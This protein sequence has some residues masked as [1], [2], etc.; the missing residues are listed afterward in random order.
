MSSR[1]FRGR[2]GLAVL[3]GTLFALFAFV[4]SVG[5]PAWL[6]V[7]TGNPA[8]RTVNALT[9]NK[10]VRDEAARFF[11]EKLTEDD[12]TKDLTR[13]DELQASIS[14]KL[15]ELVKDDEFMSKVDGISDDVYDFFINGSDQP[16]VVEAQPVVSDL[17]DALAEVDPEF[18]NLR[19]DLDDWKG[20]ELEPMSDGPDFKSIKSGL[21]A[22]VGVALLLTLVTGALYVRWSRSKRGALLFFGITVPVLG[23]I[24]LVT[25]GIVRSA[26]ESSVDETDRFA[27]AAV[28]VVANSVLSPFRIIGVTWIVL[29]A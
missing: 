28:P 27:S 11:V 21:N 23:I 3:F 10:E 13:F 6:S 14:S 17:V 29:G 12:P 9:D 8:S 24:D 7:G 19:K 25:S 26:V 20:L 22:L 18:A 1:F 16:Q 4:L 2:R 5:L 15:D